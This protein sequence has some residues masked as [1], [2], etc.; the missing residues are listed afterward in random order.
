[1]GKNNKCKTSIKIMLAFPMEKFM[2]H[3]IQIIINSIILLGK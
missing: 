1:M 3:C 2:C